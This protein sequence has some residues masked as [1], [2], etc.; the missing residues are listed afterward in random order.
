MYIVKC[1]F[2]VSA[3]N[4]SSVKCN[5]YPN[6]SVLL[7]IGS[8]CNQS[9]SPRPHTDTSNPA[10]WSRHLI[11]QTLMD[12]GL[13]LAR[14]VSHDRAGKISLGSE[15][16]LSTGDFSNND[17]TIICL[18]WWTQNKRLL[19]TTCPTLFRLKFDLLVK[20]SCFLRV[21]SEDIFRCCYP[22]TVRSDVSPFFPISN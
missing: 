20:H 6:L 9:A 12:E 2:F 7:D 13:R 5:S 3:L 22:Q 21:R 19:C 17:V 10:N 18:Q 14:M 15:R 4:W 1:F 8:Q 16:T 11:Q